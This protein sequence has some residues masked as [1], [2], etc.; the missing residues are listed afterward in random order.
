MARIKKDIAIIGAGPVGLFAIFEAGMLGLSTVVIDT[1]DFPGG[2]CSAL[3][4]EKP[5]YDIPG[6]PSIT[7]QGLIDNLMEQAKPF[8]PE[9]ILSSQ[10]TEFTQYADHLLLR[11]N[12]GK[13]IECKCLIIAAGCG[14]FGPNKPPLERLEEFE[15]KSVQY[16]VRAK[17]NFRNKH[18]VIAGGGDSA[19]DWA[20]ELASIAKSVKIVHRRDKFRAAPGTV[21]Q[22]KKLADIG[23]IEIMVPYQ[24]KALHGENG[25]L[26]AIEIYDFEKNSKLLK[27]DYLLP[28]YGLSM[29]LGPIANWGLNIEQNHIHVMEDTCETNTARVF[30]V[31]DVCHYP[32][33]LKLILTG[34]AEVAKACYKSYEYI[35]PEKP[36]HFEYSTT[37]GVPK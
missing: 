28:F 5:I 23:K 9:F 31:G 24:L 14:A 32:R 8:K 6:F 36:L 17:S 18:V 35:H 21:A 3:Y 27:A 2:Q 25:V 11:T 37:K 30:A 26:E 19:V 12:S 16:Y 1:L 20:V 7:G 13:E 29:K 33:K 34:F 22:M 10:V 4:P 15:E